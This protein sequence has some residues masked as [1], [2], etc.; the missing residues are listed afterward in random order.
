MDSLASP[1]RTAEPMMTRQDATLAIES[2]EATIRSQRAAMNKASFA[3]ILP[4]IQRS[5][6]PAPVDARVTGRQS[7]EDVLSRWE[8][9]IEDLEAMYDDAHSALAEG[10]YFADGR[11]KHPVDLTRAGQYWARAVAIVNEALAVA[12]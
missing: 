7:T 11:F 10:N 6:E 12:A 1:K 2:L 5:V 8:T 4:S 9:A 3:Q